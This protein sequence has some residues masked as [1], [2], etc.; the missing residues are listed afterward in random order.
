MLEKCFQLFLVQ[1]EVENNILK[2]YQ[3]QNTGKLSN[4]RWHRRWAPVGLRLMNPNSGH[5]F[6]VLCYVFPIVYRHCCR[7]EFLYTRHILCVSCG[8]HL[9]S[10]HTLPLLGYSSQELQV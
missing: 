5:N 6:P 2:V 1:L 9:Y 8:R 7:P 4:P 10:G 3:N